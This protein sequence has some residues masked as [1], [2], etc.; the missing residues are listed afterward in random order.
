MAEDVDRWHTAA[1]LC[2]YLAISDNTMQRWISGRGLPV[3]RVGRA[4]R[5]KFSEIDEWV[6]SVNDSK[7]LS[8]G[9]SE[10]GPVN[11]MTATAKQILIYNAQI[12]G[13]GLLIPES[14][15][16]ANLMLAGVH[17]DPNEWKK[18]IREDNVLQKRSW[19]SA[20]RMAG[21]IRN[22]LLLLDTE[23]WRM[24]SRGSA[25]V[26]IQ[27]VLGAALLHSR[28]LR[29]FLVEIV[30]AKHRRFEKSL[31]IQDWTVFFAECVHRDPTLADLSPST[32]KKVREVAFRVLAEAGIVPSVR[33][34]RVAPI[35][36]TLTVA[37]YFEAR[38]HLDIIHAIDPM[39]VGTR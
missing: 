37:A 10:G 13:G 33:S 23:G 16:I 4:L 17:D 25:E 15:V 11:P 26:R 28:L 18:T 5:F 27:M 21:L 14:Q 3:H 19:R 1:E 20:D 39:Q 34:L 36:I 31:E 24:I 2:D 30:W 9:D 22:R 7:H 35:S 8:N 12:T 29:D 6:R 38:S 32:V